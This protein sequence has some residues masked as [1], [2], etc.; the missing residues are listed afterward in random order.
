MSRVGVPGQSDHGG[1]DGEASSQSGLSDA[2]HE[3][4]EADERAAE[5]LRDLHAPGEA[6]GRG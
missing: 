3:R 2:A 1:R 5:L 6:A 4:Q